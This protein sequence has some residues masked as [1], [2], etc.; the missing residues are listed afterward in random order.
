MSG[1][2]NFGR[3]ELANLRMGRGGERFTREA[4]ERHKLRVTQRRQ[5]AMQQRLDP[6]IE[7]RIEKASAET[8]DEI[9]HHSRDRIAGVALPLQLLDVRRKGADRQFPRRGRGREPP[10]P[11]LLSG[12]RLEP[13]VRELV[14][15]DVL[16]IGGGKSRR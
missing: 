5:L 14:S 10:I 4:M 7:R 9:E 16:R 8:A 13:D 15:L 3:R 11:A 6:H 1:A 2:E 12:E